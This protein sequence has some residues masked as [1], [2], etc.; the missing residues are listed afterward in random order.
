VKLQTWLFPI[1]PHSSASKYPQGCFHRLDLPLKPL[2]SPFGLGPL[3]LQ[4]FALSEGWEFDLLL[5]LLDF[6]IGLMKKKK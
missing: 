1:Q 6:V 4:E 5:I 3:F 2:L